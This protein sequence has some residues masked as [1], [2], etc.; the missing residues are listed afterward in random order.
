MFNLLAYT[1]SA[2]Q[3]ATTGLR[4]PDGERCRKAVYGRTTWTVISYGP[5]HRA[6]YRSLD[7]GL[8]GVCSHGTTESC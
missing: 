2:E 1:D 3:F 7:A 4:M 8:R 5:A 6:R